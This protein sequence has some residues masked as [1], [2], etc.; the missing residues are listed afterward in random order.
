MRMWHCCELW[1]WLQMLLGS[2]IA[3]AVVVAATA[4]IQ[5]LAWE[6]PYAT[7][8]ALKKKK[9]QKIS[10]MTFEALVY[11]LWT[12]MCEID[13]KCHFT[14]CSDKIFLKTYYKR[15][16][17]PKNSICHGC[18]P[19]KKKKKKKKKGKSP[20]VWI[21]ELTQFHERLWNYLFPSKLFRWT[22]VI[23]KLQI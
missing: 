12:S 18:G 10:Q 14:C 8:V 7:G 16:V 21:N 2:R 13:H 9:R 15:M 23:P 3:V 6:L 17:R 1:C 5:P 4:P 11:E 20:C 22:T 19:K